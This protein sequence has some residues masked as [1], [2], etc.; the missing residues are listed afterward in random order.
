M[1]GGG[2]MASGFFKRKTGE[3]IL[4]DVVL[5]VIIW[6]LL[7]FTLYPMYYIFILSISDPIEAATM[8]VYLWPKGFSLRSY[9][10]IFK[11]PAMWRSYAYTLLY[12]SS[13]TLLMLITSVMGAYPLLEKKLFGRKILVYYLIIPMYFSGGLIPHFLLITKLGIYNTIWAMILPG[14]VSV[15]NIILTRT[16]FTSIP[17]TLK[18]SAFMDGAS[19]FTILTKIYLPLS[20][21]IL[22]VISIYTVVG[23]WNSWFNAMVYLPNVELQPLQMYLRR[24]LVEQTVDFTKL[25]MSDAEEAFLKQMSSLQLRYSMIIFTTLPVIFAY[26]FFQK[27]FIKGAMIGS[28][29]E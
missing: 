22:A 25:P 19:H 2:S 21:P 7:I 10:I 12:V 28:L 14:A 20:K 6:L 8:K 29:K 3:S 11:N 1:V 24:V 17:V 18:E 9:Q 16:F 5:N 4:F 15:W 23:I 27:Y 26:P 13:G